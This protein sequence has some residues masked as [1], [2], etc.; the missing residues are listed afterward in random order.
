MAEFVFV[1]PSC[2]YQVTTN[3]RDPAPT[4]ELRGDGRVVTMRRDYRAEGVGFGNL[5]QLKFER[6]NGSAQDLKK[7]VLPTGEYYANKDDPDGQVGLRKW[8]DSVSPKSGN[9]R[10]VYPEIQKRSY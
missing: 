9:K 5:G 3:I 7:L 1:C 10:P 4:C 6:E 8:A 2:G